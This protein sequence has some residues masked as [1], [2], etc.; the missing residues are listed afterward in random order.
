MKTTTPIFLLLLAVSVSCTNMRKLE[1]IRS[2]GVAANLALTPIPGASPYEVPLDTPV[3]DTLVVKGA[4]G[5]DIFI[6][7]AVRDEASGEMVAQDVLEAAY[8]S[9]T[10]RNVA[11]RDGKIS[12]EFRITVPE[13]LLDSKWQLRFTP[14]LLLPSGNVELEKVIVTGKEYRK[15]Q[16]TGYERYRK[17][18]STIISDTT[19]FV[20]SIMLG[21]FIDRYIPNCDVTPEEALEHYTDWLSFRR[22]EARKARSGDMFNRYIK[23]P[24]QN[25]GIRIDTVITN[26]EGAFRYDYRQPLETTPGM[27]R[28]S[29]AMYGALFDG[30][31]QIYTVPMNDSITFYISSLSTLVENRERY[32]TEII[33]RKVAA[34]CSY[35]IRFKTGSSEISGGVA[36]NEAELGRI[37]DNINEITSDEDFDLDSIVISATA[38]PEGR[39]SLNSRLSR[40]RSETM[41]KL[42]REEIGSLARDITLISRSLPEDWDRLSYIVSNDGSL[43][44]RQKELF[45]E[46]MKIRDFDA[47][48]NA[49]R[50]DSY[51]RYLK[52]SIYPGL[53]MVK[54]EFCMHRK[55]MVSDTIET[56]VIDTAYAHGIRALKAGDFTA[57]AGLL[58]SYG[59]YNAALAYCSINKNHTALSFL[60]N[61]PQ[62]AGSNYLKAILYA[63]LGDE[64]EA[65]RNYLL[66]CSENPSFIHRGNLD[67]EISSL[68]RKYNLTGL[69]GP[70]GFQ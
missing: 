11:E 64:R 28:V 63:R 57:A 67:P 29:V 39:Y 66:S 47:R 37:R 45:A 16:M 70:D 38:S 51:Y 10:F 15:E 32:L 2:N 22:N 9:A 20:D 59:D 12:L 40:N 35:G 21:R 49:M 34:N 62:T 8:V 42:V 43:D 23:V 3:G 48:E 52:D 5:R 31:R 14:V 25:E 6:M 33:S 50:K 1:S 56:T 58:G 13:A 26:P 4:D 19:L 68:I 18:L 7:K 30:N 46:K 54:M 60:E 27:K 36:E 69:S 44:D 61:S 17:F 55:N 41:V 53:R 24:I 65:V